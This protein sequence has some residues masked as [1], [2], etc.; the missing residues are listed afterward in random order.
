MNVL[1]GDCGIGAHLSCG[2]RGR[3][4]GVTLRGDPGAMRDKTGSGDL[5]E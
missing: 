1:S 2:I 5:G 4:C 3:I